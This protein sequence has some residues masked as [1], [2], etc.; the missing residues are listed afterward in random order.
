MEE[1]GN[2]LDIKGKK[3]KEGFLF[4]KIDGDKG[5]GGERKKIEVID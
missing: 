2:G 1:R 4:G 3:E 5:R